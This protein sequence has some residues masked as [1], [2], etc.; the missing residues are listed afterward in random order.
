MM[1]SYSSAPIPPSSQIIKGPNLSPVKHAHTITLTCVLLKVFVTYFGLSLSPSGWMTHLR[2]GFTP[3]HILN[4]SD[5]MTCF[6]S[7]TLQF[8][9]FSAHSNLLTM[10]SARNP[11]FSAA[12]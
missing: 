6:Q 12:I 9:Y 8:L 4:S 3:I 1:S 2:R 5:H 10:F 11:S 7:S